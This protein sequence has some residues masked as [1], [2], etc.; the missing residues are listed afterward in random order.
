MVQ[1]RVVLEK[2]VVRN[3]VFDM[4]GSQFLVNFVI[5]LWF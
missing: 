4:S 2:A 1:V 5:S 3:G